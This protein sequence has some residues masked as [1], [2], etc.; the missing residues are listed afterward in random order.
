MT[1]SPATIAMQAAQAPHAA[2][3][4]DLLTPNEVI[5][6]LRLDV[7]GRDPAERLR[8]L[9]RHQGLPVIRRGRLCL[10]RLSAVDRWLDGDGKGR[11]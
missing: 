8:T 7:D 2:P 5:T 3:L 1:T 6:Y 9:T 10:Y 4:H 11:R